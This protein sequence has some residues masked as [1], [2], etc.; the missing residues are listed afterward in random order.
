MH[1][2]PKKINYFY[3]FNET[4]SVPVIIFYITYTLSTNAIFLRMLDGFPR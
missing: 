4:G 3:T 2:V 1:E